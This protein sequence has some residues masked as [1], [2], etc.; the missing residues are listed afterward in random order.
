MMDFSYEDHQLD[1]QQAARRLFAGRCPTT[2]VREVEAGPVGY[3]P[4]L[5]Q[6]MAHLGWIG[7]AWP[8][9]YGGGDGRFLDLLPL[10]EEMGRFLVPSPHLDTVAVAADVIVNAGSEDQKKRV[11]P[12][13]AAGRCLISVATLEPSGV[14]DSTGIIARSE[15]QHDQ[16]VISGTK[17]LVGLAG[18]ADYFL[19]TART[20]ERG[21]GE[22]VTLFLVDAHAAGITATPIRN[23]A[24]A[25]LSELAFDQ[26]AVPAADVVGEVHEGWPA[27]SRSAMRAAVLQTA[28]IIGAAR[29]VLD[30]TNQY[31][32]DRAQFG[33]P[34][35]AYQ[36]VQYMVSDILID[37]HSA[38]LL[39]RQAAYRIDA[40]LP[41][42]RQAAMAIAFGKKAAAHLH[43]QA[44]EVHA[45]MGFMLEHDLQ[46]FSRRSKFWEN[47]LGD[48]RHYQEQLADV[49]SL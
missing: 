22:G 1:L 30:M 41:Y 7:L 45:G 13:V 48:A 29:A 31:A 6:E 35:G 49:L 20:A 4:D 42:E 44:H 27:F 10:Y 33:K 47:N 28:S 26:V 38:D 37:L 12:A 23:I 39:A 17:L 40:G 34:I 43:R 14:F 21:P 36:A 3:L 15:R 19:V 25:A 24:G 9:E 46:L 5:W 11:L 16:F 8:A 2:V 18:S 32:K